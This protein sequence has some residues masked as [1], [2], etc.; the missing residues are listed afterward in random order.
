MRFT[1]PADNLDQHILRSYSVLRWFMVGF[2]FVLPLLLVFGG[3]SSWWWLKEAL[4]VQD[5]LSAYY[6]A[7]NPCI[8]FQGVYRDLFVGLLAAIGFCLV[9]YTGFGKLE[10]WLLNIAGVSLL[11]VAY[12]STDWP[13]P[14]ALESCKLTPGFQPFNASLLLGLPASIHTLSAV[15]FFLA[16]TLVNF[17]TAL[18]TLKSFLTET[19]NDSGEM[20]FEY[21]V[22]SCPFPLFPSCFSFEATGDWSSGL[23]GQVSGHFPF[24]GS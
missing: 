17:F 22:L 5:S 11:G 12:F 20:S 6:H 9:I 2:G 13:N 16:I 24:T 7:G 1:A 19:N 14:A 15:I 4:P 23:N 10:N 3:I 8:P 18:N 21:F